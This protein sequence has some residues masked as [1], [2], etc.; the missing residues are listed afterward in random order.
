M[1]FTEF[2][3]NLIESGCNI[4]QSKIEDKNTWESIFPDFKEQLALRLQNLC[5][6][7]LIVEMHVCDGRGELDGRDSQ[8]KYEYFCKEI[9]K[10][11][12]FI[13]R[14]FKDYPVLR[15]CIEEAVEN[16]AAFY[17]DVLEYFQKDRK[18]IQQALC[19][20]KA[21]R[22]IRRIKG[23]FSDVHNKGRCVVR[24]VLDNGTEILYK[25]RS[26]GNEKRYAEM[27]QW[28]TRE[29][30]INQ[31]EYVILSYPDH[32][33][34]SIVSYA[35]CDS[36]KELEDYY[37][38]LGVQLFLTY[39]LGTKDLH[40][41]NIIASG[42]YPVLIDL[43]TLTNI[44][45]NRQRITANDEILYRLSQSVLYT[46]ILPFCHWNQEGKGVNSSVISGT[47]GQR[48][49]FKVPVIIHGGTS[50]MRITYQ[51]PESVKNRNL[52]AIRGE[53]Q[54]PL[55]YVDKL[56]KGFQA[57]YLAIMKK[58]EEFH[59][60]L[61]ELEDL[62]CRY[63]V[64]DTQRYSMVLSGSY[65]PELLGDRT[66]RD[67]FLYSMQKGRKRDEKA[68]VDSEVKALSGG[69]IPYF[70][71]KMN[72]RYLADGQGMRIEDYFLC[73]PIDLLSQ[74]LGELC[75]ID[76]EIQCG[77]IGV[78][79]EMMSGQ[80][81]QF[82][83]RVYRSEVCS[84]LKMDEWNEKLK[85][86]RVKENIKLL[87][88]RVLQNAVWNRGHNEVSWH[89]VQFSD[90]NRKNWLI[91]PM[92]MYLYDGLAGMLLLMHD[93]KRTDGRQEIVE[94]YESLRAQM[95]QYTDS[96]IQSL[97]NLQ[98]R[99]TG[100]YEGEGS[101]IYTYLLLYQEGAGAEYLDYAQRHAQIVGQ[102]I[103]EDTKYD[104]LNGNAG[105]VRAL[106]M[107]Y[108]IVPDR[109]YLEMA[110]TAVDVLEKSA[111]EQEQGIGWAVEEGILP[112]AGAAHGNGGILMAL[113]HLWR[114]TSKDRY[115]QL[116]EKVWAYEE[117]L[118][119]PEINNWVDIRA[120][121]QATDAHG[122]MAWCHGA[123]GILYTRMKCC[124]YVKNQK[125][126]SRLEKDMHRAYKKLKEYWRRDSWCL[127]H[128]ICGNLWILEKAS[129]ILAE[130]SEVEIFRRY[131]VW[132]EVYLLPQEKEN[133]GLLNGY[134]GILLYLIQEK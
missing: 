24:V 56:Q 96:G 13:R 28:L 29:T 113:L 6:R 98:T 53:F 99:N 132:E 9:I 12:E 109:A 64:A 63:L 91:R 62:Q 2:Y 100:I 83:N 93:L 84:A 3:E 17:I 52:A 78:A 60:L 76:M 37:E 16:M 104:L 87:T 105:A 125:W 15:Q 65:H 82:L 81:E 21:V 47:E 71:Y 25:P 46:G 27:L 97:K 77:Y 75:E 44:R 117:A 134:G 54:E 79:L 124:E 131:P 31:Y 74:K 67:C 23:G 69:D 89:T 130:V 110:E 108:E 49:P 7:T 68:I 55:L 33:W 40:C 50:D 123:P 39:L 19:Q 126:K 32:S 88:E 10:K 112:M 22:N 8:E 41:E 70:H 95:F 94:I 58:K 90:E 128:G 45:Y 5:I 4:L 103:D 18:A 86:S 119:N 118:Y 57:A 73:R 36:Q 48:Y 102:L 66:E 106:L 121:K 111:E 92:N 38:R 1:F 11:E 107:L 59:T 61:R 120:G 115:E 72:A 35:S 133:P 20:G 34:C 42:G 85:A 116:A 114:L 129:N 80:N 51:Y 30:G 122:A 127:C 14:T 43:E 26:M 101:V